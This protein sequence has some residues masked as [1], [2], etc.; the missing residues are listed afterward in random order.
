MLESLLVEDDSDHEEEAVSVDDVA[1]LDELEELVPAL[2]D[3][4]DPIVAFEEE[5]LE[6]ESACEVGGSLK[7]ESIRALSR[8]G[9]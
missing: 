9:T 2:E 8:L 1:M 4:E 3:E 5:M 6:E 7:A